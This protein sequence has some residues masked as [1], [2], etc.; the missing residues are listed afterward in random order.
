MLKN[1]TSG[2][3]TSKTISRIE[4]VIAGAGATGVLK[5]YE[6]GRLTAL[7]FRIELPSGKMITIRLP[8]NSEAVYNVLMKQ[9]KRPRKST[10]AKIREQANRTAWKLMQDWTEIQISL[11]QMGQ[12]DFLQVFLPYIWNG[13]Q[14]YYQALKDTQFKALPENVTDA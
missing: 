4:E 7:C 13:K 8:A 1:Y 2:V 5:D 9:V 3:P 6:G 10:E 14:T 11:I 12:A